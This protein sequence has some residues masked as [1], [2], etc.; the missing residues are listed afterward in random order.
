[1]QVY[2]PPVNFY[3]KLFIPGVNADLDYAFQEV[4]GLNAEIEYEE[5]QEGGENRFKYKVPKA[6]K[7]NNLVLKRG[8]VTSDSKVAQWC[9]ETVFTDLSSKIETKNITVL[10]LD[11][12][13]KAIM[14]WVFN[15]AW[16]V[17]WNFSD[18]ESTKGE[19]LIES[20]EFAYNS[21]K[22]VK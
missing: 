16:P 6:T 19:I 4:S 3:F 9:K 15:N 20:I 21:F 1:M 2:Y 22:L 13:G 18:L 10:L 11:A 8:V 5:I 12:N 7:F 17:K 14:G